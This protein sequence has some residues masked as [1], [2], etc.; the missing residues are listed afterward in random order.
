[1]E[2]NARVSSILGFPQCEC[3]ARQDTDD[4]H[5]D[6]MRAVPRRAFATRQREREQK[7]REERNEQDETDDVKFVEQ[8]NDHAFEPELTSGRVNAV[9]FARAFCAALSDPQ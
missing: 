9:E 7:E 5:D 1:M 6:D 2:W 4:E 8:L 3:D